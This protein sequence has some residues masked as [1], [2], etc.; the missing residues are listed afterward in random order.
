MH[1]EKERD[2]HQTSQQLRGRDAAA[3]HLASPATPCPW[4]RGREA[5]DERCD[6]SMSNTTAFKTR[7]LQR[8]CEKNRTKRPQAAVVS[9]QAGRG[10]LPEVCQKQGLSLTLGGECAGH[11]RSGVP[12]GYR[13]LSAAV[14]KRRLM[15][16]PV[17]AR[18]EKHRRKQRDGA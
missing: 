17:C 18:N 7:Q 12:S 15:D 6:A 3:L 16:H 9:V 10:G 13:H 8:A 1:S 14:V 2:S 4:D 5:A 11:A